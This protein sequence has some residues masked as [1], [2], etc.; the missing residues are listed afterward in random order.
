MVRCKSFVVL[1]L[2][3]L[4]L[5]AVNSFGKDGKPAAGLPMRPATQPSTKPAM[6]N[7]MLIVSVD[8]LRPDMLLRSKTPNMHA[9]F[10][11]GTFSFWA[12]TT[13]HSITLPS[14]TS[15]LTGVI[16]RK[17]EIEW[18]K[19]LPLA[20]PVYPKFPT[21][22]AVARA[23]GYTTGLAAGKS[24]FDILATP[25]SL[26]AHWITDSEKAEDVDVAREA[27]SI[28]RA[29]KPQ[30][31]FVHL[32]TIDNVGHKIGWG[33]PQQVKAVEQADRCIG[34]LLNALLEAGVREQTIILITA[35]HGGAG[36]THL[37]DDART[38]HIPWIVQGNGI[39]KSQDLTTY[40]NLVINTEDTFATACHLLGL[41]PGPDIDGKPVMEILEDRGELLRAAP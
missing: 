40:P 28:I 27:S 5:C 21:L 35:D 19:D 18:N 22:F 26:T 8:G 38:R 12:R 10:E 32:P 15:M 16:P 2:F 17:H 31:M 41:N 37:P 13:P 30:V 36:R 20:T 4:S 14:H 29:E 25:G 24:K 3:M 6:T 23:A 11:E 39:R 33:T 1:S 34:M 9:L 7:R